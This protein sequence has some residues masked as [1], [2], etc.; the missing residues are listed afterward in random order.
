MNHFVAALE[1]PVFH[2]KRTKLNFEF[3]I[4]EHKTRRGN[5]GKWSL[6]MEKACEAVLAGTVSLRRAA[7]LYSVPKSSLF[8]KVKALRRCNEVGVRIPSSFDVF[9]GRHFMSTGVTDVGFY[10]AN[11]ATHLSPAVSIQENV[12]SSLSGQVK[13]FQKQLPKQDNV[14]DISCG[15]FS[16]K[17][18]KNLKVL[19]ERKDSLDLTPRVLTKNLLQSGKR[20]CE[21]PTSV[22]CKILL[23]QQKTVPKRNLRLGG[24]INRSQGKTKPL[25]VTF[26][27]ICQESLKRIG[28]NAA[29]VGVGSARK[30]GCCLKS[31][32]TKELL[33]KHVFQ[34]YYCYV[35]RVKCPCFPV[36]NCTLSTEPVS[37]EVPPQKEEPKKSS[38]PTTSNDVTEFVTTDFYC[39]ACDAYVESAEE[40]KQHTQ[41]IYKAFFCDH[42]SEFFTDIHYCPPKYARCA[43][44]KDLNRNIFNKPEE[45]PCFHTYKE[46]DLNDF[47]DKGLIECEY[48]FKKVVEDDIERHRMVHEKGAIKRARNCEHCLAVF[49]NLI[50]YYQHCKAQHPEKPG[51]CKI[52][53]ISF[54][55]FT[56]FMAHRQEKHLVED[57]K[58]HVCQKKLSSYTLKRHMLRAHGDELAYKC[59]NCDEAFPYKQMLSIHRRV[60]QDKDEILKSKNTCLRCNLKFDKKIDYRRHRNKV[61]ARKEMVCI[62]C[63]RMVNNMS[64]HIKRVHST[65]VS[66]QCDTCGKSF[67]S[68]RNLI[69]HQL[70]HSNEFKHK[71]TVCNK[72]FKTRYS[73]RVHMRS[74]DEV[75]PFECCVCLKTFTTKQWRDK[76]LK[77]H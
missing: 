37:E 18:E 19:I 62:Y 23:Q 29:S 45:H 64:D 21:K 57:V 71:C 68:K 12:G 69:R 72:G 7:S 67:P 27:L 75:K 47:K 10:Q 58:C 30:C 55:N 59:S 8:D 44:C 76:H 41:Y 54:P 70:V 15:I 63:G 28:Y 3:M 48:C 49:P 43:F 16:G 33:K 50:E 11:H 2:S 74:H 46:S 34:F 56:E 14:T 20:K 36:S 40:L 17:V 26:C 77:T 53:R 51:I 52:C 1:G 39:Q 73:M 31:Y 42:C 61:H 5:R 13:S 22:S 32:P 35:C 66:L 25:D 6:D 9:G 65:P 38:P 24:K 60:H 4:P